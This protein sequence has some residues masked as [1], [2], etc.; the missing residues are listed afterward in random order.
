[1]TKAELTAL[2]FKIADK[3]RPALVRLIPRSVLRKIKQG[4]AND[5][6]LEARPVPFERAARPDG[7]NLIGPICSTVGLGQSCRL[8]ASAVEATDLPLEILEF[9]SD[10]MGQHRKDFTWREKTGDIAPYNINLIHLNPLV[11]TEAYFKLGPELWNGRYNIA[12]W[13]W[14]L[15]EFPEEWRLVLNLVDEIWMPSD[16]AGISVRKITD[17]PVRTM[18]Y[19]IY[20]PT[21]ASCDR[22]FFGLPQDKFLF[23]CAY[24]S[25]SI[26][27]RKNP[28]GIIRA[29]KKAFPI[30]LGDCSLVLKINHAEPDE[31]WQLRETLG[32]YK[33]IYFICDTLT[34]IEMNSLIGCADVYVSL[35]RAEGF[36]LIC[37]EAML[38]GKPVVATNWSANTEFMNE[39][40]ACPVD[41]ELVISDRNNGPYK[42]GARWAAPDEDQAAAYMRRLYEDES[43]RDAISKRA[44]AHISETLS[45]E[46]AARRVRGRIDE[47]YSEYESKASI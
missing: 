29:Y 39:D 40:V 28:L 42:K 6:L 38:L 36:G 25:W 8:I 7:I 46:R 44:R 22:A 9:D 47:I 11:F 41:C 45:L 18:P 31:L 26:N 34:K 4:M 3:T 17:K 1:M 12:F 35:H 33:N 14:E 30:E 2:L 37:A 10:K 21:D 19:P 20:A 15:E 5:I 24:D 23:L 13:L 16:F 43:Y 32:A 27:E